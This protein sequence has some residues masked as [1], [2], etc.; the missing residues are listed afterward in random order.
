M[1]FTK[2]IR[3]IATGSSEK[4]SFKVIKNEKTVNISSDLETITVK[5]KGQPF[6][7]RREQDPS[8]TIPSLFNKTSRPCPPF[9]VQPM[10]VAPNV[11]TIAELELL[12]YLQLSQT[13]PVVIVDSRIKRW[14]DTGTIPGAIHIPWTSL[15]AT[16]ETGINKLL[17]ILED[18]FSVKITEGITKDKVVEALLKGESDN[19]F[20]FSHAKTVVLFCNGSWCGQTSESVKALLELGYPAEKLKYYR[21]GMQG[22]VSLGLSIAKDIDTTNARP[23][24]CNER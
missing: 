18:N 7:I 20:D 10:V 5:H 22:W 8:A 9:C 2:L 23:L 24:V 15:T 11:E 1:S 13:E 3:K 19:L 6:T 17:T 12:N 16:N 4:Q 21:E 14:V